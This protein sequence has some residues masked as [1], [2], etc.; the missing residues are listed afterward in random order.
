[1][2]DGLGATANIEF[3]VDV[4]GVDFDG[5]GGEKEFVGDLAV[6]EAVGDEGEDFEF[7]VGERVDEGVVGKSGK[8][9]EELLGVSGLKLLIEGV[10]EKF[11]HGLAKI[12]EEADEVMWLG[13]GVDL[14]EV[15]EGGF[16]MGELVVGEGLESTGLEFC[17]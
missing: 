13:D 14:A 15:A 17:L 7:A 2:G 4:A 9:G 11:L 8:V 6:G 1:M 16:V 12:D 10:L 5:V 3:A